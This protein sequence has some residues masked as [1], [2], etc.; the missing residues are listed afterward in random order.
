MMKSTTLDLFAGIWVTDYPAALSWYDRLLGSLPACFLTTQ[1]PCGRL[2]NIDTC[3]SRR[4]RP[5]H[6]VHVPHTFFVDYLDTLVAQRANGGLDHVT[7]ETYSNG[8]RKTTHRDPDGN[9]IKLG[10]AP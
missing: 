1:R 4:A 9:E 8:V 6:T 7:G 5:D 10:G 3:I 2:R